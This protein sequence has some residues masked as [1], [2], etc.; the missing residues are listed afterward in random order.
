VDSCWQ[1]HR[2][3]L[4]PHTA[5]GVAGAETLLQYPLMGLQVAAPRDEVV[6]CLSTA[7]PAKFKEAVTAAIGFEGLLPE[8]IKFLEAPSMSSVSM[9]S[10]IF[11]LFVLAKLTPHS[12]CAATTHHGKRVSRDANFEKLL[13]DDIHTSFRHQT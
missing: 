1:S 9:P 3:I 6:V 11:R 5:V 4:D 7:H 2:Y 8:S 13:R 12:S 10:T